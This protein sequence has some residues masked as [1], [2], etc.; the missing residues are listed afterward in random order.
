MKIQRHG[1]V[2]GL[3]AAGALLLSACGSDNNAGAG[4]SNTP[5][6]ADV[7]CGGKTKLNAEGSSAQKNAVD[8]FVQ[9]Y[10]A[11]CPGTD[12]AY[13]PSGSGAGVKNFNAGQVDFGGSDSALKA[14]AETEAAAKRC[15]GNPAWN[16][17]LVFGPVAIGYKV[18]G[19]DSLVLDAKTTAAKTATQCGPRLKAGSTDRE[20]SDVIRV[21][22]P[23]K[24]GF[25][26]EKGLPA[27]G[28]GRLEEPP[29]VGR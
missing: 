3:V 12:L 6:A 13:N 9:A 1:A 23:Q 27:G 29:G 25:S 15:Q 20:V 4:G 18:S 8:A 22:K 28:R 7:A 14:G 2:L 11:A 10:Q 21:S 26:Q 5:A 16:L 19:V 24:P 17:P